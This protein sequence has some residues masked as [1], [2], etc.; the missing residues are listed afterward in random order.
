MELIS[1]KPGLRA[2]QL[3]EALFGLNG[4]HERVGAACRMLVELGK[5]ERHGNGGPGDPYTYYPAH[6]AENRPR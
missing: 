2:T 3:A 1:V 4:Y 5:V 6:F